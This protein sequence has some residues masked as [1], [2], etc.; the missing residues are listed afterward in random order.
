MKSIE[1][2][3]SNPGFN[4]QI[5]K[6]WN[7]WKYNDAS[8]PGTFNYEK[9]EVGCEIVWTSALG[10]KVVTGQNKMRSLVGSE[11]NALQHL[12]EWLTGLDFLSPRYI[13]KCTFFQ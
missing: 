10:G 7:C 2:G 4:S 6:L 8:F 5:M 1:R 3:V 13:K 11:D 12:Y 9:K